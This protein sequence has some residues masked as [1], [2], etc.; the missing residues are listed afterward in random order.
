MTRWRFA[1]CKRGVGWTEFVRDV[2]E[3]V[4]AEA[5]DRSDRISFLRETLGDDR[6]DG[7]VLITEPAERRDQ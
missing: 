1:V 7:H 3:D 5:K 6:F 2:P 4:I